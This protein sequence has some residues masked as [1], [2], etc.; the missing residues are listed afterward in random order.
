MKQIKTK[1]GNI[2]IIEVPK[3]AFYFDWIEGKNG[4]IYIYWETEDGRIE[5]IKTNFQKWSAF[6]ILNKLSKLDKELEEFVDRW[7]DDISRDIVN[8]IVLGYSDIVKIDGNGNLC[9][10]DYL[11]NMNNNYTLTPKQSFISLVKSQHSEFQEDKE[12][13]VIKLL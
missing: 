6:E 2:G 8:F 10:K 9:Y 3:L 7:G 12:W 11:D 4:D 5:G 13:L 1:S